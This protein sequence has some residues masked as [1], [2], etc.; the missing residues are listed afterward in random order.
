MADWLH[1]IPIASYGL[2][3]DDNTIRIAIGFRL[4]ANICQPHL[5][6]CGVQIDVI[7]FQTL[8]CKRSSGRLIRHN[9][10][11]EI[12]HRSLNRAGIPAVREPHGLLRIDDKR[13][14]SLTLIPRVYKCCLYTLDNS[15]NNDNNNN[16]NNNKNN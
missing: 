9:H 11:N 16:K 15:S 10:L 7:G 12:I 8:S 5:C 2:R 1:A 4:G 14:D 3:L 13:P 6:C